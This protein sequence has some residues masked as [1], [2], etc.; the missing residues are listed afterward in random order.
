ME[1]FIMAIP[2]KSALAAAAWP[3]ARVPRIA[4]MRR[5]RV[6]NGLTPLNWQ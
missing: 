1:T 6:F 4:A 3:C 2:F 5:D